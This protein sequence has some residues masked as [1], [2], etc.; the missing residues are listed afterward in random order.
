MPLPHP[1]CPRLQQRWRRHMLLLL[2]LV[3]LRVLR[4]LLRS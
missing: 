1:L 2:V 4:V 3:V